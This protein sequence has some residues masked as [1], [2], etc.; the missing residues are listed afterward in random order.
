MHAGCRKREPGVAVALLNDA[1]HFLLL[2]GSQVVALRKT[3]RLRQDPTVATADFRGRA[4][5]EQKLEC[6]AG[7]TVVRPS[8]GRSARVH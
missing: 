5:L 2:Q 8:Q 6:T 4:G 7:G 3:R 1:V